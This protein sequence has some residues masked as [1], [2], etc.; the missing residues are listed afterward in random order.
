MT[1]VETVVHGGQVVEESWA[2]AAD[3][4]LRDGK[5]M[6]VV[7]ADAPIPPGADVIDAR[8][9]LIL[10]GGVDPHCHVDC[11]AGEFVTRD[12]YAECSRAALLGGTTTLGDFAIPVRGETTASAFDTR[13]PRITDGYCDVA[14]HGGV[15][16]WSDDLPEQLAYLV[17]EGVPTVKMYTTYQ[18][19]LMAGERTILRVMDLL[20]RLGGMAV[21]HCETDTL[22][23]D[24]QEKLA[25]LGPIT[26]DL[27]AQSRTPLA[28]TSSVALILALAESV[29]APVYVVHQSTAAAVELLSAAR[30]RG[31]TAYSEAVT[32]NLVLDDSVYAGPLP[33]HFVCCPP[34]RP[35][36]ERD[37]LAGHV[38]TGEIYTVASDHNCFDLAQKHIHDDVRA[39]PN[40]LPGVQT[41]MPITFS[42]FVVRRG[43]PPTRFVQLVA[44]NPARALGLYP[45]KGTLMPGADADVVIWDPQRHSTI[46]ADELAMA[47]DF[48]PFEGFEV[49]GGARDVFVRGRPVVRE[50]EFV[51][52][53]PVGQFVLGQTPCGSHA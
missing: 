29:G 50:W 48:T 37:R 17:A 18:G 24:R 3:L 11:T 46:R 31:I 49:Q 13:R 51:I 40:G 38:V 22:I 32:H 12:G 1:A 52:E 10:P 28:E 15:I 33:E 39:M 25:E 16:D 14:L 26:A 23:V 41:R 53:E 7:D 44:A 45:R 34:M 6:A 36:A 27:M 21:M 8:G 4:W 42:E 19:A 20:H 2:G 47:T 43:L 35:A 30:L 9:C 5:V